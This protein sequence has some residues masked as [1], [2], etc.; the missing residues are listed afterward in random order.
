MPETPII[1]N[2]DLVLKVSASVD[3]QVWDEDRY[4]EFVDT[5][6][7][8]RQ[9]QKDAI[10]TALRYLLGGRYRSLEQLAEENY[11]ADRTGIFEQRYGSIRGMQQCLTFPHLLSATLD[12]AT[13]TGKSYVLYGI[14]LILLAEGAVESVLLLCPSVTI[15]REL[16]E[17]F[18]RLAENGI[19][20]ATMPCD[21]VVTTPSVIDGS[22]SI[23]AGAICIENY[24]AILT[25]VG[26]SIRESL[27]DRGDKV[28]VLNDETH[29]VLSVDQ[30]QDRRKW[31]EFIEDPV[32]GF[33]LVLGVSGTCYSD[34]DYFADVIY[35]Y[36]LRQ[37]IEE[38]Y[39]KNIEYV[40][41]MP[42]LRGWDERWQLIRQEHEAVRRRLEPYSIRPLTI[43][44]TPDIT[45]CSRVAA[46]LKQFLIASDALSAE[47]SNKAVLAVYTGAPDLPRL[48]T[49]DN[50]ASEVEWIVSV[51]MLNEGWDVKRVFI[52][53]PHEER[54][55]NSKLLIAQVLGRGLRLPVAMSQG[56]QPWVTVFNHQ[57]WAPQIRRLVDEVLEATQRLTSRP[58]A[59]SPHHFE[60]HNIQYE[61]EQTSYETH[62][63]GEVEFLAKGYV[64]L[65]TELVVR[66]VPI[67]MVDVFGNV[68][69]VIQGTTTQPV[70]EVADIA[71][72]LYARVCE[73]D[74]TNADDT[75]PTDY[76][77]KYTTEWF[78]AVIRR[79]LDMAGA[80]YL[81]DDMRRRFLAALGPL[82]RGV[83]A[84]ARW[85]PTEREF[86]TLDTRERPSDSV[87]ES[88]LRSKK[89]LFYTEQTRETLEETQLGF[90][91]RVAEEFSSYKKSLTT[92]TYD[93]KT[94][95]N[96]V[97]ADS[98]NEAK[99]IG[100]LRKPENAA[101][102]SGWLKNTAVRFFDFDYAWR[103]GTHPKRGRFSPDFLIRCGDVVLV[104]EV[105]DD[106]E[107]REPSAENIG[108]NLHAQRHFR[109]LNQRLEEI[110]SPVRYKFTFVTP[111]SFPPLFDRMR[112]GQIMQFRSALDVELDGVGEES[113]LELP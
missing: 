27:R 43:V 94:P 100:E 80:E 51:S 99:F 102:I 64:D 66:E 1:H 6:C 72:L 18:R 53:V 25:G 105:K 22:Q 112:R 89:T 45:S 24:H 76:H 82:K 42:S 60:L 29:H 38:R 41:D 73:I 101:C 12:L 109:T 71:R 15:E 7:G 26:S 35:R 88:E 69:R 63:D 86:R 14:A 44:V 5:L 74:E 46:E 23:T 3:R 79:S 39:I 97:I 95:L 113:Q 40:D 32:F 110:G 20:T 62:Y 84:T 61:M 67:E 34:N 56:E 70:Y 93:F 31:R 52:I 30:T 50:P 92:N 11:Q 107:V 98:D 68:R 2:Q 104:A 85:V 21:S 9:Y 81:T 28:A 77:S 65:P 57:A 96:L 59:D 111:Q 108:K 91:D 47:E 58:V 106:D 16:T 55:F 36:S 33:N 49:V 78:A 54:A 75:T 19:L 90:F 17:K 10:F 4:S 83:S 8:N 87:G 13:G 103:R 37:A 48:T